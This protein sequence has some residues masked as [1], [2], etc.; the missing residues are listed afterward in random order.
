MILNSIS[1]D[2]YK[3][4]KTA[5]HDCRRQHQCC[6]RLARCRSALCRL[7]FRPCCI[8]KV[9]NIPGHHACTAKTKDSCLNPDSSRKTLKLTYPFLVT[10]SNILDGLTFSLQRAIFWK[11]KTRCWRINVFLGLRG[12]L[13]WWQC[14]CG[15]CCGGGPGCGPSCGKPF[16]PWWGRVGWRIGGHHRRGP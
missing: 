7:V 1:I 2:P 8:H 13:T 3:P 10:F 4:G 5:M 6:M 14:C 15:C 9:P 11:K 16:G 12:S